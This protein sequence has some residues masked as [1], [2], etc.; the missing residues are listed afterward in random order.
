MKTIGML[1]T[2][3][4]LILM[5][6]TGSSAMDDPVKQRKALMKKV[7]YAMGLSVKSA[8]GAIPYDAAKLEAALKAAAEAADKFPALLKEG[9]DAS[10]VETSESSTK[11]WDNME[12][13]KKRLETMKVAALKSAEAAKQ[14]RG[15]FAGT[16]K[17]LGGNCASCHKVYRIKK[18]KK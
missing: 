11:V 2:T 14:G 10:K 18:E 15:P 16:L 1:L 4:G 6:T 13:F 7:G 17:S 8:K 12:D 3:L 5:L 9:T